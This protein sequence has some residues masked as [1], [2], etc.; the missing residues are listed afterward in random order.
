[1]RVHKVPQD[2][3][4]KKVHQ[5]GHEKQFPVFERLSDILYPQV[6]HHRIEHHEKQKKDGRFQALDT[7]RGPIPDE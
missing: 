4:K 3:R 2:R 5:N 7:L 1:M 6:D